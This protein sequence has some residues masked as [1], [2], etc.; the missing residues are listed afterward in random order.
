LKGTG[1]FDN[2]SHDW[3][4]ENITM[5]T[6]TLDLWLKAGYL[7]KQKLFP[8]TSGT[9]Q[10]S[11]ISPTLA[12]MVLDGLEEH[13]DKACR[14]KKIRQPPPKSTS[15]PFYMPTILSSPQRVLFTWNRPFFLPFRIS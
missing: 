10:G 11:I 9:P 7:E 2:I 4:L 15:Y 1:C 14:I 6:P 5:H 8:T 12:N 13:I 3:L